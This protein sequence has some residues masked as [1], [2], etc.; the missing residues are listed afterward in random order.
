MPGVP[1]HLVNYLARLL[2]AHRRQINTPEG[3]TVLG[4]VLVLFIKDWR[5]ALLAFVRQA[6]RLGFTLDEIKEIVAIKRAGRAPC[7]KEDCR[8]CQHDRAGERNCHPGEHA[9]RE[10]IDVQN[11]DG[12]N[13]RD[14]GCFVASGPFVT[15]ARWAHHFA[16]RRAAR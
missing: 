9:S 7:R 6:Q 12:E 14:H 11:R 3:L 13:S 10:D 16:P 2:A 5:L 1:R 4:L 8:H 15:L